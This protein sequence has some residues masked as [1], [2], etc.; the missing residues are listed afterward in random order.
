MGKDR[1]AAFSDGVIAIIITIMVLE[2]HVPHGSDWSTLTAIT[3]SFLTY[4]L[5]FIYVGIYW[6]QPPSPSAYRHARRRPHSL[7]Q[8]ASLVLTRSR[9]SGLLGLVPSGVVRTIPRGRTRTF[10]FVWFLLVACV[11]PFFS[12][13]VG[14]SALSFSGLRPHL[15]TRLNAY[16]LITFPFPGRRA[17]ASRDP[18]RCGGSPCVS[19]AV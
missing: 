10:F 14:M 2:L 17:L 8:L 3:P 11:A 7:G 5:S 19:S 12:L 13:R 6:E 15:R 1:L 18:T 16:A 4:V 9:D